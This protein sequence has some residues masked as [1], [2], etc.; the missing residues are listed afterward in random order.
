M[1]VI[2]YRWRVNPEKEDLFV[3]NWSTITT[4]Y[5]EHCG[6]LGSRLHKGSDGLYYAYAKWPDLQTRERAFL[7]VR[8]E[9]ARLHLKDAVTETFPEI[10]LQ[11]VADHLPESVI[12]AE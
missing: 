9:L 6:S 2:L 7:D 3:E 8:M 12:P 5:V 11:V 1:F 10:H 4:H